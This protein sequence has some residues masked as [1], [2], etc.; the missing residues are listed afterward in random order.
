MRQFLDGHHH[1]EFN[2]MNW[3]KLLK[4]GLWTPL[5]NITDDSMLKVDDNIYE[6][7][8]N[9]FLVTQNYD[10]SF[11]EGLP[12]APFVTMLFWSV[13]SEAVRHCFSHRIKFNNFPFIEPPSELLLGTDGTY[14]ALLKSEGY[15]TERAVYNGTSGIFIHKLIDTK[16]YTYFYLNQEIDRLQKPYA[17]YIKLRR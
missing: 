12:D 7:E 9:W 16:G 8:Q 17:I 1:S 2:N 10:A 13:S 3:Q 14:E 4:I 15:R 5:K 11:E 6:I